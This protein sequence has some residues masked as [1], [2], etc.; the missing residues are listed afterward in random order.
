LDGTAATITT[1]D[2]SIVLTPD[3]GTSGLAGVKIGGNGYILGP[4]GSRNMA[5][6]YNGTGGL[7]GIYKAEI[8]DT[9]QSTSTTTGSFVVDGGAG[10]A[11]NLN[12][13][14]N[15]A[16]TGTLTAGL[17][18]NTQ[19]NIV[20]YDSVTKELSYGNSDVLTPHQIA[21]GAYSMWISSTDGMVTAP[22]KMIVG[23]SDNG[24]GQPG[25]IGGGYSFQND[26]GWDTG[27][28]SNTDGAL[29]F[30]SNNQRVFGTS[31]ASGH[32]NLYN[33]DLVLYN[34][35]TIKDTNGSAIGFGVNAGYASQGDYAV[36]VG[37]NAGS[38]TQGAQSVAIGANA[39]QYTQGT[40]AVALG[41]SAGNENQGS[42]GIAIGNVAGNHQGQYA[43][44][45]G[46]YAGSYTG[47]GAISIGQNSGIGASNYSVALG[48]QAGNN[49]DTGPL[50]Q[51]AIAIGY[52]A[53]YDQ[54]VASSIVLNAS[55]DQLN[56]SVA[57]LFINPIRYTE[58]QDATYDG[59][60]FY[61]SSTKEVRYSYTL[62][63]GSF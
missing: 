9:T 19:T 55:G 13:G 1:S 23:Q 56:A 46:S 8:Y 41:N 2:S 26:G 60:V 20:Y 40:Y 24:S 35:S 49:Y 10:I 31:I 22:A 28:F 12:V 34:G 14:G 16:I 27:M 7:L 42:E 54:G 63:G 29:D 17:T 57:G 15:V 21:N 5:L 58:T 45:L 25:T 51:Y 43:I 62:D 6:N 36:A 4:N 44:A 39:G 11:K 48:Y 59:M 47:T 37:P 38:D 30:F 18:A 52:R 61:N 3:T 32:F 50:G 53:S 33:V